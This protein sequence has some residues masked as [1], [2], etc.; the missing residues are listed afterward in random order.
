[1]KI[2]GGTDKR[3][4]ILAIPLGSYDPTLNHW[5]WNAT[6][7]CCDFDSQKTND[8]GYLMAMVSDIESKYTVDKKRLFVLGHSN[9]GFM[10]HRIACDQAD[11]FAAV[12]S[13]AGAVYKDE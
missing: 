8:I 6:D 11:R 1:M 9:G 12:V 5:F 3:G 7:S 4:V 10:T 13:L 2:S